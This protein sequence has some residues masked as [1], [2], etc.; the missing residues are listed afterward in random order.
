MAW[1]ELIDCNLVTQTESSETKSDESTYLRYGNVVR[2]EWCREWR[3]EWCKEPTYKSLTRVFVSYQ[4][5]E[6]E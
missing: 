3:R 2:L 5:D 1:V 4:G 6:H